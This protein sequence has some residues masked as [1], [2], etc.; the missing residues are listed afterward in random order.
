MFTRGEEQF[1]DVRTTQGAGTEGSHAQVAS[2]S[3]VRV[4]SYAP[5]AGG[6]AGLSDVNSIGGSHAEKILCGCSVLIGGD[7]WGP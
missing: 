1:S 6:L 7:A 4:E 2:E 3:F 5:E